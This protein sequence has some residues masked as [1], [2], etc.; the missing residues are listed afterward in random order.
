MIIPVLINDMV[1]TIL[2]KNT[3]IPTAA[4]LL[5]RNFSCIMTMILSNKG[6][7]PMDTATRTGRTI[8][9]KTKKPK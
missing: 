7:T 2:A 4:A 5:T 9:L 8:L 6:E 3:V 1:Q